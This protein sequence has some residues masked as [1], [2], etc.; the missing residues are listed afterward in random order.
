MEHELFEELKDCIKSLD[1]E[2]VK[3]L[4]TELSTV[5]SAWD[6]S[7]IG[8]RWEFPQFFQ[9][10]WELTDDLLGDSPPKII[11]K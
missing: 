4:Q 2:K 8:E 9:E 10:M 11:D 1:L 6:E 7:K 3:I 5:C